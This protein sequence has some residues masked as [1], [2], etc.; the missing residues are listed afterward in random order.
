MQNELDEVYESF[1]TKAK[2]AM[3][4]DLADNLSAPL[5]LSVPERWLSSSN[6][7]LIIGQE[8]KGWD[9]EGHGSFLDFLRVANSVE[10]LLRKYV[11]F[12]FAKKDPND[13]N[14]FFWRAYRKVRKRFDLSE[15]GIDSNVLWSNLIRADWEK[16]SVTNAPPQ[17]Q[18]TAWSI[19]RGILTDEIKILKPHAVI[20]FTGPDYDEFLLSEFAG[21]K[22]HSFGSHPEREAAWLEHSSLPPSTIRTYHPGHLNRVPE[23]QHMVDEIINEVAQRLA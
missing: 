6:R 4:V 5:L 19:F 15:E 13:H 7:I 17:Q 20:F 16:K 12:N 1:K 22:L 23:L 3:P 8:T 14:S 11:E 9:W 21:A 18:K 10:L 2:A